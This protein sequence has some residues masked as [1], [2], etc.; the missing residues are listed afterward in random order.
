MTHIKTAI[1]P[2]AGLGS[3][4]LPI[5][6]S[7]PKEM[8]PLIDRP[9]IQYAV[10]E[11]K[12]AGIENLIFV[13][14]HDK[15]AIK[16]YFQTNAKLENHLFQNKKVANL[17]QVQLATLPEL[18]Y[19]FVYQN[20][21][22]GLG[23]AVWTAREY[24]NDEPF[25]VILPD[26]FIHAEK[27]CL[28]QMIERHAKTGGNMVATMEVGAHEISAYG[29]LDYS[30]VD[31]NCLK[32]NGMVEKPNA[33]D[34]PST[35]A[36]V[37]RYIL[38]PSVLEKLATTQP[39]AGG[40]IQLTDAIAADS[41]TEQLWGL[42]FQG[43]RYDCGNKIGYLDAIT[44]LALARAD[45]AKGFRQVINRQTQRDQT[46]RIRAAISFGAC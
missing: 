5:T 42:Q 19:H 7:V 40:E 3:R 37:G 36:V 6:K 8:L 34:A 45:T 38:Q 1:F 39:G 32:A 28:T 44:A 9:L 17:R 29:C 24:I 25:A 35:Q 22:R 4:F 31:G 20:E 14:S 12:S 33:E 11:A 30:E 15:P 10:D 2:V 23:H 26:D 41:K 21:P 43:Q 46:T 16:H 18:S 13:S 27:S